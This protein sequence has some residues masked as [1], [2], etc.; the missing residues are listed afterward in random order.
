ML[1][2]IR[3][4][5][6]RSA[7]E[8]LDRHMTW[9]EI[10]FDLMIAVIIIQLSDRLSNHLSLIGVLRCAALLIPVMWVWVSYTTFAAR[11]DNND[12]I[13]WLIT[14]VIM[15]CGAVM[16][17]QIPSALEAGSNGFA[18]GFLISQF[19][20][21]ILYS[22]TFLDKTTPRNMLYLYI[23]GFGLASL[24]WL[25]SLFFSTE[26]FWLW[27]LG[28]SIYLITPW[29]GRKHILSKVPLNPIYIP[30]R[31]CAFVIIILGQLIASVVFGLEFAH[32]HLT[33]VMVSIM[34]FTLSVLIFVQ[35]YRFIQTADYRCTLG[36]GQP[37]IYAHIPLIISLMIMCAAIKELIINTSDA[38][39]FVNELFCVSL[40]LYLFSFYL[41]HSIAMKKSK[42]RALSYIMSIILILLLFLAHP[43]TLILITGVVAVFI[44]LI[45]TNKR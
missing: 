24:C 1:P 13:H 33:S 6:L 42:L 28:M 45:L 16:A 7:N 23:I 5:T 9:L 12:S 34:A 17:V 4:I 18:I 41:L 8:A 37:Y 31:F 39:T 29:V 10:F 21:L 40:I 14:F 43:P 26:K 3:K 22:R 35:Y 27:T 19:C 25:L 30:E 11:F 32:W 20:L 36:S 2:Y 15:F 38:Q 44:G